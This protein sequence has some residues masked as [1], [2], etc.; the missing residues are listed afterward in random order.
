M[1]YMCNSCGKSLSDDSSAG[2]PHCCGDVQAI[3]PVEPIQCE[4]CRNVV[5]RVEWYG[6]PAHGALKL[7]TGCIGIFEKER[8]HGAHNS[9]NEPASATRQKSDRRKG[10]HA[11]RRDGVVD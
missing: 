5:S 2:C 4:E 3:T 8:K 7:C 1:Y 6:H 9:R 11:K 10:R